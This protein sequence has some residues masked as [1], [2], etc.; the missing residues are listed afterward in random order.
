M[1]GEEIQVGL[2]AKEDDTEHSSSVQQESAVCPFA[3]V[4]GTSQEL[5]S[6][7]AAIDGFL[8]NLGDSR[9]WQREGLAKGTAFLAKT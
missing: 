5:L 9:P 3:T 7:I 4:K 8:Q 2:P 1:T 6:R